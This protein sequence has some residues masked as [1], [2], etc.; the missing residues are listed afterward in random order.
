MMRLG[1]YYSVCPIRIAL[2]LNLVKKRN[3]FSSFRLAC[4]ATVSAEQTGRIFLLR[5]SIWPTFMTLNEFQV[6][7]KAGSYLLELECTGISI[8]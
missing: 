4:L 1:A 2:E 8:G 6:D 5:P 3:Q 7:K